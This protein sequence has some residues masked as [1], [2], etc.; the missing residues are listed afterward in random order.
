MKQ[1]IGVFLSLILCTA[2]ISNGQAPV[3]QKIEPNISF[4]NTTIVITG[5]GFSTNSAQLQ[6]WFDHV[7]EESYQAQI[8]PLK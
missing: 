4:S 6:V 5:S 2:I 7:R 8:P 3:I 1:S